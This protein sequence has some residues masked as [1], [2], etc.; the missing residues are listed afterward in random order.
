MYIIF[1]ITIF[2]SHNF[3]CKT[4]HVVNFFYYKDN[5]CT[6]LFSNTTNYV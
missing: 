4:I 3:L 6:Q 2:F 1:F 5:L